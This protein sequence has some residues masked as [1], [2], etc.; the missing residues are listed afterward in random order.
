M[1][2]KATAKNVSYMPRERG[3]ASKEAKEPQSHQSGQKKRASERR[4]RSLYEG[5]PRA[6]TDQSG[7]LKG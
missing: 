1:A 6:D 2:I 7:Q 4:R 5:Q 3:K